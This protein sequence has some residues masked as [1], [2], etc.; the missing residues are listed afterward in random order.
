[1]IGDTAQFTLNFS[2]PLTLNATRCFFHKLTIVNS[3]NT[4]SNSY[5][6]YQPL[7]P[8]LCRDTVDSNIVIAYLDPRDFRLSLNF[9]SNVNTVNLISV[10]DLEID[11]L[12][13]VS[14][15]PITDAIVASSLVLNRDVRMFSFDVDWNSNRVILH[16]SDYMDFSSFESDQLV[17]IDPVSGST[18]TLSGNSIP[19]WSADNIV[20]TICVTLSVE[21]I[22]GLIDDSICTT[23]PENCACYFSS[24]LASSHS[25]VPVQAVPPSL[26]LLVSICTCM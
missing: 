9:F 12:P 11:F 10:S 24:D 17:L 15:Y 14:L 13:F 5:S 2:A 16:F 21:D 26:P 6:M 25:S 7:Y 1:M 22:V 18:H 8:G 23:F 3:A 19:V 4:S 20:R